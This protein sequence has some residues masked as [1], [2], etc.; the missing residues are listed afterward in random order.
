MVD[1]VGCQAV[2]EPDMANLTEYVV[3]RWYRAPEITLFKGRYGKAQDIWAAGCTFAEMIRGTPLFPGTTDILE[4]FQVIV[5]VL[6]KPSA[7]DLDYPLTAYMMKYM[8]S[9]DS[10][11]IGLESSLLPLHPNEVSSDKVH[12]DLLELLKNMLKFN[13]HHRITSTQACQ[14]PIFVGISSRDLHFQSNTR[15]LRTLAKH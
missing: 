15:A 13:P 1:K 11:E 7:E 9:L 14:L 2:I 3:S 4:Q 6:G 8:T 10:K 12:P 5:D